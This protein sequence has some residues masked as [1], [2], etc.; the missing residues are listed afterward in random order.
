MSTCSCS[1]V[2][3]CQTALRCICSAYQTCVMKIWSC[4]NARINQLPFLQL[5]PLAECVHMLLLLQVGCK[6]SNYPALNLMHAKHVWWRFDHVLMQES[7]IYLF[8]S[9]CHC[10]QHCQHMR[11]SCCEWK[12]HCGSQNAVFMWQKWT[13]FYVH[14]TKIQNEIKVLLVTIS[15]KL[16]TNAKCCRLRIHKI[17]KNLT[18]GSS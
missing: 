5:M 4:F 2:V 13:K 18:A 8:C 9:S 16:K 7:I 11:H 1:L 14:L 12:W 17:W 6:M 10:H 15:D 3:K